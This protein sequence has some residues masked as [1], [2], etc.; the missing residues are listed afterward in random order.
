ME[1]IDDETLLIVMSDH[2][3]KP[4]RRGVNLNSWLH[5]QGYLVTKGELTG[6][7]WMQ[8]VDWTKTRAFAVGLGGIYL[9]V[10]GRRPHGIVQ[11]GEEER[12]LRDE[13]AERLRGLRDEEKDSPAVAEVYNLKEMYKGP[14]VR[15]APDLL[16]GFKVGY[17]ASWGCATG[18]VAEQV[19][20]DNTKSWSGDHCMNPPD[21]P[22]I[23][24]TN[25]KLD[26]ESVSIMDIGPTVLD[27]F[28][29]QVPAYCDGKPVGVADA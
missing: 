4:F 21:V 16:C 9:N 29:V 1:K 8:D 18:V 11:P 23:F 26:V 20:E 22:G 6:A 27:Q 3:F 25:R 7:E 2:G 19:F 10:A 14:Y 15:E 24:F 12:Q 28:G 17:R 5:Q 13:I